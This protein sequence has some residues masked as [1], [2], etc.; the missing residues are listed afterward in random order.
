MSRAAISQVA[1]CKLFTSM[2][3]NS[4][5]EVYQSGL[6]PW[7]RHQ[8]LL[9]LSMDLVCASVNWLG[10]RALSGVV[11][12][13]NNIASNA[14]VHS[15]EWTSQSSTMRH[16]IGGTTV[17]GSQCQWGS[18][19]RDGISEGAAAVYSGGYLIGQAYEVGSEE[20][21]CARVPV[22]LSLS[23][24]MHLACLSYY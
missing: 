11:P 17:P 2:K 24:I 9:P 15:F 3:F 5:S 8:V 19:R 16:K 10:R 22:Q 18:R 21:R 12:Y 1:R 23:S 14:T 20:W 6:C 13:P 7:E 4:C